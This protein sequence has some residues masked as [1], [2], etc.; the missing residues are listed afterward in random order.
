MLNGSTLLGGLKDTKLPTITFGNYDTVFPENP[1]FGDQFYIT[2]NGTNSGV[3]REIYNYLGTEIGWKVQYINY[4][5]VGAMTFDKL[6]V[7]VDTEL[8]NII[9]PASGGWYITYYVNWEAHRDSYREGG[10]FSLLV[11]DSEIDNSSTRVYSGSSSN[12]GNSSSNVIA[13]TLNK[14]DVISLVW[15]EIN[16]GSSMNFFKQGTKIVLEKY[17]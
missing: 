7:V 10:T 4:K 2:S 11:N 6:A 16:T 3:T 13:K 15:K 8:Y 14:G 17:S 9:I 1:A 12:D 5:L